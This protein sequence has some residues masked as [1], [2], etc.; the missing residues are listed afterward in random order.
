MEEI[1]KFN[2]IT[3]KAI[4]RDGEMY[5]LNDLWKMLGSPKS[6]EPKF[7]K[8]LPDT[9]RYLDSESNAQKVRKSHLLRIKKGRG[10]GTYATQ[11]VF[12]EY[13]R[14]LNKDLA[15][16]IN[17][18]FLQEIK[19]Q[20]NPELY[21]DKARAAYK[22]KGKGDEWVDKRFKGISTRNALTHTLSQ[23]GCKTGKDFSRCTI[24]S[25]EGLFGR[26][27][28]ALREALNITEKQ[29]IRDNM[30]STQLTILEL[31]EDLAKK[32]IEGKNINGAKN[33][34]NTC[35]DASQAISQAVQNF[36]K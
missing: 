21:L 28:P 15:V 10:G 1:I 34:A 30:S 25:Y 3:L 24:A 13:A 16:Q 20:Q 12:L 33:C 18:V 31:S 36:L 27:V 17:E 29:S 6:M 14:Y 19:A 23:H 8:R 7:W 5:S 11:R 22:R 32:K 2:A 26:S 9:E 35:R 4:G